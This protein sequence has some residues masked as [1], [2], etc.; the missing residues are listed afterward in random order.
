MAIIF[1]GEQIEVGFL[2]HALRSATG[3]SKSRKIQKCS[4]LSVIGIPNRFK[5]GWEF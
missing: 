5:C 3:Y 1:F 4:K 2:H